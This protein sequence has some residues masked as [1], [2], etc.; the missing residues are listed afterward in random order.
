MVWGVS[1]RDPIAE[2]ELGGGICSV[3]MDMGSGAPKSSGLPFVLAELG[4][5]W[6]AAFAEESLKS[7]PILNSLLRG[8][9]A[10]LAGFCTGEPKDI[11]EASLTR[12]DVKGPP[13]VSSGLNRREGL[14]IRLCDGLLSREMLGVKPGG[15]IGAGDEGL[16]E[17]CSWKTEEE[18]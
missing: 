13:T 2:I 3:L 18:G 9:R 1:G 12:L 14:S 4:C 8:L 15:R 6:F 17:L 5:D 11:R 10:L 16:E 7:A